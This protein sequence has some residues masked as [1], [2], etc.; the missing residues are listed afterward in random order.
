MHINV[1]VK[2]DGLSQPLPSVIA[3]ILANICEMT[4]FLNPC[5][6]PTAASVTTRP[7]AM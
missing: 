6:S 4:L 2:C 5:G 7:R 3:G 1:S